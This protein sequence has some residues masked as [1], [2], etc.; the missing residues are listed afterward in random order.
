MASKETSRT[1]DAISHVTIIGTGL[2]GGSIGL[3]LKKRGFAGKI[4]GVGRR[5]S[6]LGAAKSRGCIDRCELD[7]AEALRGNGSEG[8]AGADET[9]CKQLLVIATPLGA[10][11]AIFKQIAEL[12]AAGWDCS[13][14]IVTDAGST[15]AKVCADAAAMLPRPDLF[16]G[17][18]PMAGSELQGPAHAD[19]ELFADRLCILT[20]ALAGQNGAVRS[21]GQA[22]SIVRELWQM[23]GMSITEKSP[24]DHDELVASISHLPHAAAVLLVQ[25]ADQHKAISVGSTGF[26]DTTRVASG[27]PRVWTDIFSTNRDAMVASLD[28]MVAAIAKLRGVIDSGDDEALHQWLI[29]AKETRDTWLKVK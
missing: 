12:A 10:F 28:E 16:V 8:L 19:A 4:V 24:V 6:T 13:D 27:D 26:R 11:G 15:K 9:G 7:L 14:L 21:D 3:G 17:A 2:L 22:V 5:E 23:L 18:H 29:N 20:P 1:L 25:L